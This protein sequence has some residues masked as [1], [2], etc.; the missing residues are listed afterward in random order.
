MNN[1]RIKQAVAK[2]VY[3]DRIFKNGKN[4]IWIRIS[5]AY[6]NSLANYWRSMYGF[7]Y[8]KIYEFDRK[9][10]IVGQQI[11]YITLKGMELR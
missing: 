7:H 2:V 10:R 5:R 4:Y 11:G 3:K 6:L 9:H 8:M 1:P